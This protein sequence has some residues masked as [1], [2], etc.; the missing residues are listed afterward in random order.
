MEAFREYMK[1]LKP[2]QQHA[3]E[4]YVRRCV[5]HFGEQTQ[6]A[7][8]T[9]SRVELFAEAQIR[10]ADPSAQDRVNALKQYFQFIRKRGYATENFGIHIRVRRPTGGRTAGGQQVRLEESPVEMTRDGLDARNLK[11]VDL[12]SR[13]PD[14]LRSI[15]TAREDKDFRE[16]APLQA[17]REELAM[18][19]GQIKQIE[20]ELKRS[21]VVEHTSN[22][23]SAMGSTVTVTN[24]ETGK[25]ATFTLVGG[26]EANAKERKISVESPVGKEL[27]GKRVGAE[28]DVSVPS[29]KIQYRIDEIIQP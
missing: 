3:Q 28:V 15:A 17:A 4:T 13:R 1:S 8:L 19:D 11:L 23:L 22:D 18:I 6:I 24:L 29:G 2:E 21:V 7:S 14:V 26:R 10:A 27:L 16:N 9:G 12:Q 20:A 5:E 25:P